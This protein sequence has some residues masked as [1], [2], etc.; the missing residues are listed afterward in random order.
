MPPPKTLNATNLVSLSAPR[1]AELL[2]EISTGNAAAKRHLRLALAGNAGAP[3]A[4]REIAKRLAGIARAKTYLDYPK[5]KPLVADLESQRAA[6]LT[7]VAPAAPREAFDLLWQFIDCAQS[8]LARTDDGTGRLAAIFREAVSDLA[9]L[10]QSAKLPS[11]D[12]ARRAFNALRHDRYD[13]WEMLIPNL[14]PQLG[15]KGLAQL[16]KLTESWQS[17]PAPVLPKNERRVVAWSSVSGKIYTDD[18]EARRRRHKA[19]SI[20]K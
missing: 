7:H 18:L 15:T 17:E 4:A 16:K 19:T 14:A 5:I 12:L 11:E 10:A 9:P 20:L 2:I 1:L 3:E 8:V 13:A 6:I